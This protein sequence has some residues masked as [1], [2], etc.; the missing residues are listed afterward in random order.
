MAT[1]NNVDIAIQ[2]A[3]RETLNLI[4]FDDRVAAYQ[5]E[6]SNLQLE[7]SALI[8]RHS[9]ILLLYTD[10]LNAINVTLRERVADINDSLDVLRERFTTIYIITLSS[11]ELMNNTV[12]DFRM[13]LSLVRRIET[14]TVPALRNLTAEIQSD[15]EYV[16]S[17]A[18]MLESTRRNFSA[19][20]EGLQN[21]TNE[22]LAL[23]NSILN[24]A[25]QIA[26]IQQGLLE[27]IQNI[28][29]THGSL[30]TDLNNIDSSLFM[31]EVSLM[32]INNRI[33]S[34]RDSLVEVPDSHNV[35]Y[36]ITNASQTEMFVRNEVIN[37]IMNQSNR[38]SQL[39][40]TYNAQRLEAENFF[41][42]VSNLGANVTTLLQRIQL[43]L[44]EATL[45]FNNSQQLI[46]DA[47]TVAENLESFNNDTFRIRDEVAEA[48]MDIEDI[49][50]NASSAL[51]H[52]QALEGALLNSSDAL[53][54]AKEVAQNA[55][56][57]TNETLQV[58]FFS[59]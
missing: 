9:D 29:V 45:L 58:K 22:L 27:E 1:V 23:I 3:T 14:E 11:K 44:D 40:A 16:G 33:R 49:S 21:A 28:T 26:V 39:N 30:E 25:D 5:D 12:R 34:K 18:Q 7:A 13:A 8:A 4:P 2:N 10:F 41:Q 59:C 32:D 50:R 48:M 37:E 6:I 36:L 17:V 51:M 24:A 15:S 57:I 54:T 43:A 53:G 46:S 52:S 55:L 19:Q 31:S 47:K 38:F 42:Q 35:T 56:S 20:V